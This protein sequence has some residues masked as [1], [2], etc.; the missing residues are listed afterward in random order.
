MLS[1][2]FAFSF[3]YF[4]FINFNTNWGELIVNNHSQQLQC[5]WAT[6]NKSFIR[7]KSNLLDGAP[8]EGLAFLKV[9]RVMSW[10]EY[11]RVCIIQ[12]I[13]ASCVSLH[14]E[15]RFSVPDFVSQLWKKIGDKIRNRKPGFKATTLVACYQLLCIQALYITNED[16]NIYV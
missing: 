11:T 7:N 8:L 3:Y 9:N 1:L 5:S 4:F 13:N 15:P 14:L 6:Y 10:P 16:N 2:R 12:C